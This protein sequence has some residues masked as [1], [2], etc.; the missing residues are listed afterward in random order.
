MSETRFALV[1]GANRGIGLEIVRQ[2]S[3]LGLVAVIAARDRDKGARAAEALASE[4]LDPPVVGLDVTD[5]G[6]IRAGVEEVV[7]LLGRIDVLV[8]NAGILRDGPSSQFGSVEA[9]PEAIV[10]QTWQTNVLG[11]LLM[12]QA[13]LPLMRQSGYGRI[14]NVSSGLGQLAEMGSGWP[15]YRMS[16]AALNALTR[17]T[18]SELAGSNIK[19]NAACPGWVKTDMGGTDAQRSVEEGADT[20]VWLA[21]L[22]DDGPSGGFF[23]D[24]KPIAW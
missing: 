10:Q 12:T 23:R 5:P 8:N 16:K 4:G 1:T 24:R 7:R 19:V 22:E 3:R 20:P 9:V 18:A 14:V 6:S 2:L 17:T 13:V 11:P 21:T 15:A